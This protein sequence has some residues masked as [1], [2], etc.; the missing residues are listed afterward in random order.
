VRAPARGPDRPTNIAAV[1]RLLPIALLVLA[2]SACGNVFTPGAA[3][4]NGNSIPQSELTQS[5]N[6]AL[7]QQQIPAGDASEIQ[8]QRQVLGNLIQTHL[9]LAEAGRRGVKV[10]EADVQ[11]TFDQLRGQ[12]PSEAD[13]QR[14]LKDA[15]FTEKILR[16]RIQQT[17][18]INGL[19]TKL[20]GNVADADVLAVYRQEQPQF[21]QIRVRHILFLVDPTHPEA[22]ALRQARVVLAL[23]RGGASFAATAKKYSQDAQSKATGGL[24]PGW[25][26]LVAPQGAAGGV[27][28]DPS[29]GA[30]AWRARVGAT[31]GPVRAQDGYHLLVTIGKRVQPFAEVASQLRA[32]V[33][34]QAGERGISDFLRAEVPR[35]KVVVNPRYGDWDAQSGSVVEHAA[36]EPPAADQNQLPSPGASDALGLPGL[37]QGGAVPPSP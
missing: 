6:A 4:V 34:Q 8:V 18:L 20:A 22:K 11:R 25:Q 35:A 30:A 33:E 15:G 26:P 16:D 13:F 32:Q 29:F 19:R 37:P 27:A 31:V 36:F 10:V 28:Q 24:L 9:L 7:K 12:F 5:V 2:A 23:L 14:Q 21:R 1:K 17:T 3:I